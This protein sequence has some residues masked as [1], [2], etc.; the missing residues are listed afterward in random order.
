[1]AVTVSTTVHY[2][3]LQLHPHP[4]GRRILRYYANRVAL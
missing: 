1:V 4:P 3:K 2:S